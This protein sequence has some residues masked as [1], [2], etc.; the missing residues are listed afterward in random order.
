MF[1]AKEIALGRRRLSPASAEASWFF[2]RGRAISSSLLI[3]IPVAES[4]S[5]RN[6]L[7]QSNTQKN[8][9]RVVEPVLLCHNFFLGLSDWHLSL[10]LLVREFLRWMSGPPKRLRCLFHLFLLGYLPISSSGVEPTVGNQDH[11][12]KEKKRKQLQNDPK[13]SHRIHVWY[14]YHTCTIRTTKYRCV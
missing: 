4:M 9:K 5:N 8:T 11:L 1:K 10:E 2:F 3:I 13:Q 7:L 6:L 12:E 14:I